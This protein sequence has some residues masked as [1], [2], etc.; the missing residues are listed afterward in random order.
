M[1]LFDV[2][3]CPVCHSSVRLESSGLRVAC[4]G[5]PQTYPVRDGIPIMLVEPERAMVSHEGELGARPGYSR[6]K[7][8]VVL[9]SLT[10]AQIALDFG[11]GRQTLDDPRII[12]MDLVFDPLLDVVGDVHQLPFRSDS[13]DFVFGGAVMEHL[14]HPRQAADEMYR[15]LRPGGYVY[16]DWNFLAAYH[17]YPHHYFNATIHGVDQTFERFA[18]IDRGVA[19]FH[20]PAFALRSVLGTYLEVFKPTQRLERE[21][22]DLLHR[23]LW[24]PLDEFDERIEPADRHRVAASVYFFGLKQPNGGEHLIPAPVVEAYES[25]EDLQ[26]RFP[27]MLDL[28]VPENIMLWA[29]RDGVHQYPAIREYFGG[30]PQFSKRGRQGQMNE[31]RALDALPAEL[32][33]RPDTPL[34]DAARRYSLSFSRPIW[35]RLA[36]AWQEAGVSGLARCIWSSVKHRGKLVVLWFQRGSAVGS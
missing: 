26:R 3:A 11:A 13:L 17:G 19:P 15:V 35:S 23:V 20:G 1:S 12:R 6:W 9:K 8:R 5:C 18:V 31:P 30:L 14:P 28:S 25:S 2:L 32:L 34:D 33:D 4:D 27:K 24:H 29:K 21:F 36:D 7:E 16:A 10:D 22:V